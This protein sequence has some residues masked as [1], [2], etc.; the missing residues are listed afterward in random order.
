MLK[1]KTLTK[2]GLFVRAGDEICELALTIAD[3]AGVE[4][5]R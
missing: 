3:S 1:R 2:L 4:S 5:I